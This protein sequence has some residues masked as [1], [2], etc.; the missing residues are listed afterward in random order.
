MDKIETSTFKSLS[1]FTTWR[2][3]GPAEWLAEPRDIPEI[4][5][6]INW[7][8]IKKIPFNI[9]GCGSNLLINDDGLEGLS[10]VLRKFQGSH[11][12]AKNGIIEALGGEP[13]PTLSRRAAKAGLHGLEW[14]IGIPGTVGGAAVMNAG[15]QGCCTAE[16]LQSVTV[17]PLKGGESFEIN[18]KDLDF[19]YRKSLL[20]KEELLVL[21]SRF[22][23]E[24]GHNKEDLIQKTNDNLHHRTNTQPYHLPSC[25]SVFR[26]PKHHH[27]GELIENLGLKGHRIGGAEISNIHANF[28][29]NTGQ[30]TAS[31]ILELIQFIKEKVK[32]A[33]GLTLQTEVKQ[34]G[35]K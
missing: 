29:V 9:I 26:N 25:G 15:A 20:Q 32:A 24:T 4:Q 6:L 10:L 31:N 34:L 16:R 35:F 33:H 27:A 5:E 21:S 18:Q 14:A 17:L 8:N 2:V 12:D 13:M 28:I 11:I 1:N 30:A 22:R 7:A 23:L 3:G 19:G